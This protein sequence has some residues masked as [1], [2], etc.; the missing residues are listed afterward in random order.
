MR[1]PRWPAAN[2]RNSLAPYVPPR[3][4]RDASDSRSRSP[5]PYWSPRLPSPP[6]PRPHVHAGRLQLRDRPHVSLGSGLTEYTFTNVQSDHVLYVSFGPHV[7]RMH[8][9]RLVD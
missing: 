1:Y 7:S 8:G 9:G 5:L 3:G 2:P 4:G 6:D